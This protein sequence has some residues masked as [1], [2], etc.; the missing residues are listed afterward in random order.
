[1]AIVS[2][3]GKVDS[4]DVICRYDHDTSAW[5]VEV[6]ADYTD[7]M[8]VCEFW[9]VNDR[10]YIGYRTAVLYLTDGRKTHISFV[11]YGYEIAYVSNSQKIIIDFL[12]GEEKYLDFMVRHE[13]NEKFYIQSAEYRLIRRDEV[14]DSGKMKVEQQKL[15]VK[16][17]PRKMGHYILEVTCKIADETRKARFFIDVGASLCQF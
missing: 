10:G 16:L 3:Y 12:L 7:G 15:S 14:E 6:P 13:N 2:V 11:D 9:C 1:M 4:V 8:Y 5:V 17:N